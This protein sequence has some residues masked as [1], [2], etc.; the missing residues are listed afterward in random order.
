MFEALTPLWQAITAQPVLL[1]NTQPFLIFFAIFFVLYWA[2]PFKRWRV[3][4][5]LVGSVYFYATWNKEL[6]LVV[7]GTALIDYLVALVLDHFRSQR[8]RKLLLLG[9]LTVNL[10]VLCFFK[11]RNFFVREL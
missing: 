6:A 9:S 4:L 1:F 7:C 8:L 10:A 2:V 3:G 11:Y 5:L